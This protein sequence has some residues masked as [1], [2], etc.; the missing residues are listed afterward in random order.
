[1]PTGIGQS[2]ASDTYNF[3]GG[4]GGGGVKGGSAGTAG[5]GDGFGTGGGGGAGS[6]MVSSA[7]TN[8]SIMTDTVNEG[9]VVFITWTMG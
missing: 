4:G 3:V 2:A 1:M 5:G 6:S 7:L 8:T 9:G